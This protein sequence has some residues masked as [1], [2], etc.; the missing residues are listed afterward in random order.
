MEPM[1]NLHLSWRIKSPVEK[2]WQALVDPTEIDEWGAGPC[3]MDDQVGTEFE[4]WGGQIYG[5]NLEVVPH[6]RL[7]Q[8]WYG[9]EWKEPSNLVISLMEEGQGTTVAIDQENIPDDELEDIKKGWD[10][11]YFDPIKEYLEEK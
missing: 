3:E 4:L 6:E 10:E 5:K 8:E 7:T 2:V 9:G 11:Y 1:A